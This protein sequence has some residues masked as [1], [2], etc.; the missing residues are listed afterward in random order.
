ML[1]NNFKY[2]LKTKP[3]AESQLNHFKM[4][5]SL[6]NALTK[7]NTKK[8]NPDDYEF[9][10]GSEHNFDELRPRSA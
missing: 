7:N 8:W 1:K 2:I 3:D 9:C 4:A 10:N 6:R 5:L